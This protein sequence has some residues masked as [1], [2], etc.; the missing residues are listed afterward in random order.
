MIT[1][2]TITACIVG[3]IVGFGLGAWFMDREWRKR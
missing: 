1:P 3:L 2:D